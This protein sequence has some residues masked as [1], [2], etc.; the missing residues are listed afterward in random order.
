[1]YTIIEK[2]AKKFIL[3]FC[4][5]LFSSNCL[6]YDLIYTYL[7]IRVQY[8]TEQGVVIISTKL[9]W[10]EFDFLSLTIC[11]VIVGAESAVAADVVVA[12]R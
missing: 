12:I 4:C 7:F 3:I 2:L 11:N 5:S 1:M 10:F 8:I 6:S 9:E